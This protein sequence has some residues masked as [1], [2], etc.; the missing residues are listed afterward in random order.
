M[1]SVNDQLDRIYNHLGNGPS[2]MSMGYYPDFIN[3]VGKSAYC[4]WHH[5]LDGV[6]VFIK[7]RR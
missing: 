2:G 3:N 1:V 5:P 4:G 7:W 6:F